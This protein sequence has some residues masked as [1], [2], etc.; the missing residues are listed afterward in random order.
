M[1]RTAVFS[2]VLLLGL[3][4]TLVSR[5]PDPRLRKSVRSADRNGWIQV[6]LEGSPAEIGYQHG[7]LL[8]AEIQDNLKAI[9]T[10]LVHEEKRDWDTF[11]KAAQ[12]VFW[13]HVEQEY[14]DE[15]NGIVEGL[16]ARDAK[17]DIWDLVAM[18]AWLELPYYDKVHDKATGTHTNAAGPGD[19]CSAFIATGRYTK[20]GRPVIA[21]NNWTSYSSGE[22]W[23]V[24]FDIQPAKGNRLIMDGSPGLIHSGD[25]FGVNSAGIMITET[26]ISGFTG[27]DAAGVPEFVRA[28][29]AMQYSASIDDFARFMKE[30]NNG[31]YANNWLVADRK[32][33]EVASLELG[34][35]NVILQRTNDGFFVGSN[36][37][38]DPKLA[39]EETDFD[40]R[41][42]SRSENARHER[43]LALMDQSKGNID[44]ALAQKF[45]GDHFDS[46]EG[47]AG[48]SERTLC[49]HV[50]SSPRGMGTWQPPYAPAGAVQNKV[51][52]AASAEKMSMLALLGH[53]CGRNFKA[54]DHLARHPEFSWERDILKDMPARPWTRFS[55]K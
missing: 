20:D 21:H 1:Q 28:R 3:A 55:A 13:P 41:D 26:T 11:R 40:L 47:R 19:H 36:F 4:F 52:D 51:T 50:E 53:A 42:R 31:G 17:L 32:T 18:N 27:F 7:Y 33:N 35:K 16:R 9:S 29:K 30:G 44:A 37:P 2:A 14:R 45:L 22:R 12:D 54:T 49:G 25:D 43:W 6:H 5:D 15:L 8:A 38:A 24:I 39:R 23:N 34:L 46:F 48:G 10:E